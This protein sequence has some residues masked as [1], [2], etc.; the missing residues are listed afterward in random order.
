MGNGGVP[1]KPVTITLNQMP[2][3]FFDAGL[4]KTRPKTMQDDINSAKASCEKAGRPLSAAEQAELNKCRNTQELKA[5]LASIGVNV[6]F[7]F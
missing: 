3:P 2:G 1:H 4:G 7:A 6:R 5:Y